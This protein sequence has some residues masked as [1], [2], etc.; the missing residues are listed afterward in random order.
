MFA[1]IN[2]FAGGNARRTTLLIWV[3]ATVLVFLMVW[4]VCNLVNAA[5]TREL[6]GAE[7]D[8]ANLTRVT[9]EH[10]DRTLRSADQVIRFV[11]ERYLELGDKLDLAAL[12]QQGVIDTEIFNQ[13]GVIDAQ[14][15]YVLSNH[16]LKGR[17]DLSD[18]EHFKVHVANDT[19]GL[20]VSKPVIG[21]ASGRW[22][23]QL[24]RRITDRNGQ[25][26]G[27]VVVSLDPSYFTHFYSDLEMGSQG[28]IALYGLDGVARARI[29]GAKAEFGNSNPNAFMFSKIKQGQNFGSYTAQSAVDQ[30]ERFYYYRKIPRYALVVIAGFNKKDLFSGYKHGRD[31]LIFQAGLGCLFIIAFAIALNRYLDKIRRAITAR[32]F[33]QSQAEDRTEQLNAIFTLSPD[34]FVAFDNERR[35]KYINPAFAQMAAVSNADF[36]RMHESAFSSW[37]LSQCD[38]DTPFSGVTRLRRI[39]QTK[40][41][42]QE[43]LDVTTDR[44]RILKVE[45]RLSA[46][47]SVSQ[48]LYFR[49]ITHETQLDEM[50][51]EFL[52]TAAHELRT[53][54]AS[55]LGFSELLSSRTF[56]PTALQEMADIIHTQSKLMANILDELLNL[57]RLE[58][59]RQEDFL[60]SPTNVE[61]LTLEVIKSLP[62]PVGRERP[63]LIC[64]DEPLFARADKGKL[65]QAIVNVLTN[66]YKYSPG[67]GSVVINIYRILNSTIT[68]KICIKVTD[69][70]IGMTS[71]QQG[72]IFERFYRADSSGNIPGTGLGMSIVKNIVDQHQGEITVHSVM[73]RGTCIALHLPE[74]LK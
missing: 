7:R 1:W 31:A 66:A 39:A 10:A 11:V 15:I 59:Q 65:R 13:V 28:V 56:E 6:V 72:R 50:K 54:M 55:I 51:S 27:V 67:G 53:P 33:A 23:I 32:I 61:A 12:S 46:S 38:K 63:Q 47:K 44:R 37:L 14:G 70:G 20:F 22:S 35:V 41:H 74:S 45:L 40:L 58:A 2:R 19:V 62:L 18:R 48:I 64:G 68:P 49:D 30:V 4:H 73:D 42:I 16:P 52:S 71:E 17:L 69:S 43:V 36:M 60:F 8:L 57:A 34:G 26:A 9:Q 5:Y 3:S 24:T 29:I 21:R 25:F